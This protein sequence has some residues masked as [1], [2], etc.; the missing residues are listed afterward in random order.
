[1]K[2]NVAFCA[3]DKTVCQND[4]HSSVLNSA[5]R[6]TVNSRMAWR[7]YS[8]LQDREFGTVPLPCHMP[9]DM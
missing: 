1:M 4:T 7:A 8:M 5:C 6:S 9:N 2:L 3:W